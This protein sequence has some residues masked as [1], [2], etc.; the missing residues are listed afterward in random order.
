MQTDAVVAPPLSGARWTVLEKVTLMTA[1]LET[2]VLRSRPDQ[3]EVGRRFEMT[4]NAGEET[5]PAGAAVVFHLRTEQRQAA[6][7]TNENARTL[8]VVENAR[9]RPFRPVLE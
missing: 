4:R 1:A 2:V 5:W 6:S 8:F 9:E 3:L 7:A